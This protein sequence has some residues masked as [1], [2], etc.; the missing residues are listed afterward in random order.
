MVTDKQVRALFRL[1]LDNRSIVRA[2]RLTDMDEK[3]ARK[4][5]DLGKLPKEVAKPH[6]WAA[7]PNPFETVWGEVLEL[8]AGN[9]G[10]QAKTIFEELQRRYPGRFADNQLRTLQRHI[11]RWRAQAGP[12]KEVFFEQQHVP[13]R[14]AAPRP[15][16]RGWCRA[17]RLSKSEGGEYAGDGA[18]GANGPPGA[19]G[20]R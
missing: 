3:T 16:G 11:K 15:Q 8:L 10:L 2:A 6:D 14:E 13:G 17:L 7:R 18:G 19:T 20:K 5:R 4:Y 12:P 1:L 9:P